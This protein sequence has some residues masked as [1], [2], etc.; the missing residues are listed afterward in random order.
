MAID[1]ETYEYKSAFARRYVRKGEQS[2]R[3]ALVLLMLEQRFGP[4]PP[5][6]HKR[7]LAAKIPKLDEI[8][9]RLITASTLQEALGSC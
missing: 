7:I 6:A 8:G 2:G 1:M 4:L 3:A 9:M 5:N